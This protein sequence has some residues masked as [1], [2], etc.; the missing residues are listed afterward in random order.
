MVKWSICILVN[1][2]FYVVYSRPWVVFLP[3]KNAYKIHVSAEV[4]GMSQNSGFLLSTLKI[5][6]EVLSSPQRK[7][8]HK[9]VQRKG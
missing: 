1:N 5:C 3:H 8:P 2:C 6:S 9:D 7:L 4:I